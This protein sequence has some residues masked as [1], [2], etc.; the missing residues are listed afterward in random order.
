LDIDL[1]SKTIEDYLAHNYVAFT[2]WHR[3]QV[4]CWRVHLHIQRALPWQMPTVTLAVSYITMY[5]FTGK[6]IIS[7]SSA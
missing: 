3:Q 6:L 7:R 2:P 4:V 5:V 1:L